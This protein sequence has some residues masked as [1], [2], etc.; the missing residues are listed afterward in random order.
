MS[1]SEIGNK[2]V[3]AVDLGGTKVIVALVSVSGVIRY[4]IQE[5]TCQEGGD[6]GIQQIIRMVRSLFEQNKLDAADI[7]GMCIGLPAV[8]EK[9]TDFVIWGPNLNGWKNI[10]AVALFE[11]A[12][13]LAVFLE[14]DGHTAALGEWWQGAGRGYSSMVDIIIGTGVGGGIILDGKLV[15]GRNRLAGAAGWFAI[16]DNCHS[17]REDSKKNGHWESMVA[18]PGIRQRTLDALP[19]FPQSLLHHYEDFSAKEVF[20]LFHQDALA[21]KIVEETAELMGLGL[22]NIVSILNPEIIVLGGSIGQHQGDLL[23]PL[24]GSVVKAWAQPISAEDI[25]FVSSK[26]GSDAGIYGAAYSAFIRTGIA[27]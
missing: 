25:V 11:E 22:A 7:A 14:Y 1:S 3:I 12:L 16:T 4:R 24:I 17:Q 13:G 8:L 6:L 21:K 2:D 27:M 23:L 18:G 19:A 26:L 20:A 5:P 15:R 10:D 9:D